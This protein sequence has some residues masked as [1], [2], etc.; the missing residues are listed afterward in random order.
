MIFEEWI[1]KSPWVPVE[2]DPELLFHHRV[3]LAN[4]WNAALN[5]VQLKVELEDLPVCTV[6]RDL[7]V[8]FAQSATEDF[9]S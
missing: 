8:R 2:L 1:E 5:A 9:K 6:V 7:T 3:H 4:C